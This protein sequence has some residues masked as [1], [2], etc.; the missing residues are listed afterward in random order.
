VLC[1]QDRQKTSQRDNDVGDDKT[2]E[3][4]DCASDDVSAARPPTLDA[5]RDNRCDG[6]E[7]EKQRIDG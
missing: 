5:L 6:E 7:D 1:N 4:A 2:K 3:C